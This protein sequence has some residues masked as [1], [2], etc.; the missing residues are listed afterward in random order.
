MKLFDKERI[1]PM[2]R[3]KMWFIIACFLP[4]ICCLA[5]DVVY[6]AM[7]GL[8][9]KLIFV[10]VGSAA[11]YAA[12][13]I[14]IPAVLLF[15][16]AKELI[17]HI[18]RVRSVVRADFGRTPGFRYRY[19]TEQAMDEYISLLVDDID[20]YSAEHF[21]ALK[22][23]IKNIYVVM[24]AVLCLLIMDWRLLLVILIPTVLAAGV[25]GCISRML[26]RI[27]CKWFGA[28]VTII[29]LIYAA[30]GMPEDAVSLGYATL[31][32]L[33]ANEIAKSVSVLFTE[34]NSYVVGSLLKRRNAEQDAEL[35]EGQGVIYGRET[36][37]NEHFIF[38]MD[39]ICQNL[40][41]SFGEKVV[42]KPFDLCL[43]YG[44][45]YLLTGRT[46]VGKTTLL[47][48]LTG[49]YR[50]YEGQILYDDVELRHFSEKEF[51][52]GVAVI[53]RDISLL[54]DTIRNNICLEDDHS[55]EEVARAVEMAGLSGLIEK[56]PKGL[57][58]QITD[59]GKELP[60]GGRQRIA[61]ARALIRRPRLLT[62]DEMLSGLP[63]K[64][65][66]EIESTLL[67][68]DMTVIVAS[69]RERF[70]ESAGYDGIMKV[71]RDKV[72]CLPCMREM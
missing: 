16:I 35:W 65:A 37:D 10:W 51:H 41:F 58:T 64:T 3:M 43:V 60:E 42:F 40:S 63:V 12:L 72:I 31:L 13:F 61:I 47:N 67:A 68:L 44:K 36:G 15:L 18:R 9:G 71:I 27:I 66:K 14:L 6:S 49:V 2:R 48:L 70:G 38:E 24:V 7:T 5:M 20:I 50:N 69:S 1:L 52:E 56:L 25:A 34:T 17:F 8:L 29:S 55:E 54:N 21:D 39:I 23:V 26:R 62:A 4:A 45:K 57:D 11:G 22:E 30:L 53:N 28:L 19:Y 46:G 59:S 32:V 33:I